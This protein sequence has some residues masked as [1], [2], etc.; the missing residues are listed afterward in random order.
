MSSA[1]G[2]SP[3]QARSEQAADAPLAAVA[4]MTATAD[5]EQNFQACRRLAQVCTRSAPLC[6]ATPSCRAG[7]W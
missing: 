5:T 7:T 6:C 4:Q 3:P 2:S 1:A